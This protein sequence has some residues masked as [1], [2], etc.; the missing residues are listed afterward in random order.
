MRN[1]KNY[2]TQ[3]RILLT[4][5]DAPFRKI[6]ILTIYLKLLVASFLSHRRPKKK[7]RSTTILGLIV[8]FESYGLLIDQFEEIFLRNQYYFKAQKASPII[9]DA[10]SNIGVSV[11]Y[12]K[13]LYPNSKIFA[14]EP[15]ADT[16][17]LLKKMVH[18]NCLTDVD[19]NCIALTDRNGES[20]LYKSDILG[21]LNMS[22]I[23]DLSLTSVT[24]KTASLSTFINEEIDFAK[25][26]T[27]GSE[28][29]IVTDLI[30]NQKIN[31]LNQILVEFHPSK[32]Q[33]RIDDF[34]SL[35]IK[36]NFVLNKHPD[37]NI[38]ILRFTNNILKDSTPL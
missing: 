9:I 28:V 25:I 11:M 6:E 7:N 34:V 5:N 38:H 17:Q 19:L 4:R 37:D 12:F 35:F 20:Q 29:S 30:A 18:T 23:P 31:S 1:I 8:Y 13:L 16:F 14:F 22:L 26:D 10:G 3:C 36:N 33:I 15:D 2:L 21:D 32:V 27:E 24:V